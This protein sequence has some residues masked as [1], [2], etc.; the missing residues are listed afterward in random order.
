MK[1]NL[2]FNLSFILIVW[3]F[4]LII[5]FLHTKNIYKFKFLEF[6]EASGSIQK[7]HMDYKNH[8]IIALNNLVYGIPLGIPFY[9]P[10]RTKKLMNSKIYQSYSTKKI[11]ELIDI[12]SNKFNDFELVE[13][14]SNFN[15]F[16]DDDIFVSTKDINSNLSEYDLYKVYFSSKN[17]VKLKQLIDKEIQ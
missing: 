8:N 15:I 11:K 4:I 16:K 12:S 14:Y 13:R 6:R 7:I 2:S 9:H 10:N 5:L 1:N 17:I 3:V